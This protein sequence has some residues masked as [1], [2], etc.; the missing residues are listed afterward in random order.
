MEEHAHVWGDWM[1]RKAKTGGW[2]HN[3]AR[4]AYWETECQVCHWRETQQGGIH[5]MP[6]NKPTTGITPQQTE[7]HEWEKRVGLA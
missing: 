3:T 2:G 5:D 1:H 6:A 4:K 7:E